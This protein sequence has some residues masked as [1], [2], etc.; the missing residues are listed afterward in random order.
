MLSA[1]AINGTTLHE[2]SSRQVKSVVGLIGLSPTRRNVRIRPTADGAIDDSK[3]RDESLIT[4]V[5]DTSGVN[6]FSEFRVISAALLATLTTPSLLTWT[7]GAAG[8]A[9]QRTVKLASAVEPPL[10][11]AALVLRYGIVLSSADPVAYSQTLTTATGNTLS[12]VGGGRTYYMTFNWTYAA[13]GAGTASFTNS[14][15]APT[16]PLLRIYGVVT[17]PSIILGSKRIS[18]LG[19][20]SSG[21]YV[22]IDLSTRSITRVTGSIR[23][24]AKNMIDPVGTQWFSLPA[25]ANVLQLVAYSFDASARL[26][27]IGR[28]AYV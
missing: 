7:E 11:E 1:L 25:G 26:D 22:E 17:N 2:T 19:T 9:L 28:S 12:A 20:V 14:G 23:S 13:A 4:I 6:A 10:E 3:Y 18:L 24:D 27:V 15:N 8:L 16:R 5:G 21:E